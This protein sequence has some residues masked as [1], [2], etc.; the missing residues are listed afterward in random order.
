[1]H[2]AELLVPHP[3]A[4]EVEIAIAKLK[5]YQFSGVNQILPK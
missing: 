5:S 4:L 3:S 2:T 1:M